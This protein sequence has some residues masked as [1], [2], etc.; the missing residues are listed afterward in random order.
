MALNLSYGLALSLSTVS[1]ALNLSYGLAL[2][3]STVSVAL[4]LSYSLALSF[5]L[6]I[7]VAA[8]NLLESGAQ[9]HRDS[10]SALNLELSVALSLSGSQRHS[11][12]VSPSVILGLSF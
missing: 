4:S 10:I 7:S 12:S 1:V 2:S 3:L 9:P 6:G 11:I 5:S 8:L